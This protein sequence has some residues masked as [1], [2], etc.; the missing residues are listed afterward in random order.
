MGKREGFLPYWAGRLAKKANRF[1]TVLAPHHSAD[2]IFSKREEYCHGHNMN[3]TVSHGSVFAHSYLWLDSTKSTSEWKMS[4]FSASPKH[5][6][7]CRLIQYKCDLS[8]SITLLQK[9][10]F[11]CLLP[12]NSHSVTHFWLNLCHQPPRWVYHTLSPVPVIPTHLSWLSWGLNLIAVIFLGDCLFYLRPGSL[13]LPTLLP[14]E[15]TFGASKATLTY[16]TYLRSA[17][18][19]R[20]SIYSPV[21]TFTLNGV[22]K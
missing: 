9:R 21:T 14:S 15:S 20:L 13:L 22:N 16:C 12:C 10:H 18:E 1:I 3:L 5:S 17:G 8:S 2:T 19:A 4:A 7:P 6:R 11:S